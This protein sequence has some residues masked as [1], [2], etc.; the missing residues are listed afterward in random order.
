[1]GRILM[2][3]KDRDAAIS[4]R[5]IGMIEGASI[6]EDGRQDNMLSEHI[7]GGHH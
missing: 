5:K 7:K 6:H 1:M 2:M 4:T 3:L